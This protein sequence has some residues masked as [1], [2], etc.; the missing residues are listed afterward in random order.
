[1][2][3]ALKDGDDE[4]VGVDERQSVDVGDIE[5]VRETVGDGA[6]LQVEVTA[7]LE[8]LGR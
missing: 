6:E 1:M 7:L 3:D 5:T 8:A 4:E 2:T